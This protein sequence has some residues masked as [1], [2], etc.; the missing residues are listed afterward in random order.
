MKIVFVVDKCFNIYRTRTFYNMVSMIGDR[1]DLQYIKPQKNLITK[2]KAMEPDILYMLIG[3]RE[4]YE[5]LAVFKDKA[6]TVSN[7]DNGCDIN[8]NDEPEQVLPALVEALENGKDLS[9]VR[10]IK[11]KHETEPADKWDMSG[12][13]PT[14]RND[15]FL[16]YTTRGCKGKCSFCCVSLEQGALRFRDIADMI[17]EVKSFADIK[18]FKNHFQ[19]A[20]P[21]FDS[22]SPERM[23]KIAKAVI[24][25]LP[26]H[27]YEA[28]FRPDFHK[29]A[30]EELMNLLFDSGLVG[31]FVGAETG[32][33]DDL[34]LYN[35]GTTFSDAVKTIEL[36]RRND[37]SV[38]CGFIM[39]N[40][41]STF[42]RLR[43][44]LGF[45]E[46]NFLATFDSVKSSIVLSPG[47]PIKQAIIS[48]GI[49][50]GEPYEVLDV[51][52]K[53]LMM[54]LGDI[55]EKLNAK[56]IEIHSSLDTRVAKIQKRIALRNDDEEA[57]NIADKYDKLMESIVIYESNLI[58]EWFKD[59]LDMMD[60]ARPLTEIMAM[61]NRYLNDD[62]LKVTIKY[63]KALES[64]MFQV[65]D[66]LYDSRK[67]EA[68]ENLV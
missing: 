56:A 25:D 41:F 33:E 65:L 16:T 46:K 39:F 45:L 1:H 23:K 61:S 51:I 14:S 30:D 43:K 62:K 44:N 12:L 8:I 37:C 59:M 54:I 35:K 13:K 53:A 26:G 67:E 49:A 48:E 22:N 24:R 7:H 31:A 42:E 28:N 68:Q 47:L 36:L 10:G 11:Y 6:I 21:S 38:R 2:L 55:Q 63:F 40:P 60:K 17:T 34:K 18:G 64:G 19:F 58:T 50:Y 9:T 29:I 20:D 4:H 3:G 5:I 66:E 27:T 57:Y 32:N 52:T 15:L